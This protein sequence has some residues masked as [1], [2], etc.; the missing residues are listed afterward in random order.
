MRPLEQP[1][2][3]LYRL[4]FLVPRAILRVAAG[5]LEQLLLRGCAI[6]LTAAPLVRVEAPAAPMAFDQAARL[7]RARGGN[8]APRSIDAIL[9]SSAGN[10]GRDRWTIVLGADVSF[11]PTALGAYLPAAEPA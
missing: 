6:D 10:G 8:E 4:T 5:R 7:L 3:P 11:A 9:E 1:A 2:R